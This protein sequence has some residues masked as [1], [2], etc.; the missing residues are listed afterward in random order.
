MP[1]PQ[2][3]SSKAKEPLLNAPTATIEPTATTLAVP[4][5]KAVPSSNG[6][7]LRAVKSNT[8]TFELS[9]IS[10]VPAKESESILDKVGRSVGIDFYG[11][12]FNGE[13]TVTPYESGGCKLHIRG[14]TTTL[15]KLH[16]LC[17]K[18]SECKDFISVLVRQA[19]YK[20]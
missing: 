16:P 18:A 20:A 10:N 12:L 3:A 8:H 14:G 7:P 11:Y 5:D 2:R 1:L 6:A 19:D 13:V 15:D 9:I 4:Q 17:L